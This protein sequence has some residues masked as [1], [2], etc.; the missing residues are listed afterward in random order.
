MNK[1]TEKRR[2]PRQK[3][4]NLI[5]IFK[6]NPVYSVVGLTFLAISILAVSITLA[7]SNLITLFGGDTL[8]VTCGGRGFQINR[9]SRT[10]VT[11]EC[12]QNANNPNPTETPLP[13]PTSE[14]SPEPTVEPNP[15]SEPTPDPTA[16]PPVGNPIAPYSDAPSCEEIGVP[17]NDRAWH[18]IWNE[19]N[20]CHWNHE[21]KDNP[22]T[23]DH[24]FG[25]TFYEWANGEISYPWQ[26][27]AGAGSLFTLNNGNPDPTTWTFPAP[28]S[29][30]A[31]FENGAKHNVY[32]WRV[33]LGE[34]GCTSGDYAL[35]ENCLESFRLQAHGSGNHIGAI[36]SLHS[37]YI[38]G[39]AQ[40]M[41]NECDNSLGAYLPDGSLNPSACFGS[42]GGWI[43]FGRLRMKGMDQNDPASRFYLPGDNPAYD[44]LPIEVRPYRSHPCTGP[45]CTPGDTGATVLHSWNSSGNYLVPTFGTEPRLYYGFG[46]HID[47]GWGPF[48]TNAADIMSDKGL[49]ALTCGLDFSNCEFNSSSMGIFRA[50]LAV[51]AELDGTIYD[52]DGQ[53]NGFITM[54]GYSNRYGDIMTY[55][56]ANGTT[57]GSCAEAGLDCVP[58]IFSH[59]PVEEAGYRGNI[60]QRTPE[61][62][63]RNSDMTEYDIYFCDGLV[64]N[65]ED[66]NGRD[67]QNAVPSGW[68]EFPN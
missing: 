60:I 64:C 36:T 8:E 46:F 42:I 66:G 11:L 27:Y 2:I 48:D 22:H 52:Q 43:D 20:G 28:P 21:H 65:P 16:P 18:S 29:D 37:M 33:D 14:P 17:H 67:N 40:T 3:R 4:V 30:P 6:A 54:S 61:P 57:T 9:N 56:P 50:Y 62:G 49:N 68:I 31:K 12:Q 53:V 59:F 41:S 55:N 19:Q 47:D 51:P 1:Q 15:T 13:V 10:D 63:M 34:D 7:Q 24:L 32:F 58:F 45:A 44:S 23:G 38:Q 26:T 5:W 25:T 35:S 39:L